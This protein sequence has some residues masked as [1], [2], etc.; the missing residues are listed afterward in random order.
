MMGRWLTEV[1]PPSLALPPHRGKGTDD[2]L[3]TDGKLRRIGPH[4][5][6]FPRLDWEGDRRHG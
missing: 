5:W 6:P 2:E 3:R 4:P 1:G